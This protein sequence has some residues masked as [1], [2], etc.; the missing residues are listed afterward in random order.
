VRQ[1][2]QDYQVGSLT[3]PK[4]CVVQAPVWDI[5]HDPD[6]WP[7]PWKFDPD[8]FS[9]EN[10]SLIHSTAYMPFGAGPRNCI[11]LRFAQTE[12]KLVLFRLL[13]LFHFEACEKT[14]S[15]LSLISPT[16]EISPANGVYLKAVR[17]N[18]S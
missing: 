4:D 2:Q 6:L 11:G 16:I 8:R 1:C 15:D 10:K 7:E 17:R 18:A 14:E 9:P 13:K 5:H 3:I 12:A